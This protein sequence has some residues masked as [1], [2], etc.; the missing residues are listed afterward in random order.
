MTITWRDISPIKA[1]VLAVSVGLAGAL[2]TYEPPKP[3]VPTVTAPVTVPAPVALEQRPP[4]APS[5]SVA[6][7]PKSAPKPTSKPRLK[8][9]VPDKYKLIKR[10][11]HKLTCADVPAEAYKHEV[12]TV[13]SF[14]RQRGL[15]A[16]HLAHLRT[17]LQKGK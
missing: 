10:P 6:P 9:P 7:P 13:L 17:C 11:R 3:P 2:L 1:C 15:D 4:V 16:A 14:A 12:D 8:K 5:G